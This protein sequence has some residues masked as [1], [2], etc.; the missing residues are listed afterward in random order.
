MIVTG[1]GNVGIGTTNPQ[2]RLDVNGSIYQRGSL[3]HADYVLEPDYRL[4]SIEEHSKK[5]WN[6][7]HLPAVSPRR[8]DED[9]REIVDLGDRQRG[10]LEELE[11]AHIYIEQLKRKIEEL[12]KLNQ[13][14]TNLE[15]EIE[16][17]KRGTK[18][19]PS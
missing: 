4:E 5:M 2:G 15:E 7:K 3:L 13:R 17:L 16:V 11:T 14:I 12:E 18:E 19:N 1:N 6:E 9:G 8:V 10:I